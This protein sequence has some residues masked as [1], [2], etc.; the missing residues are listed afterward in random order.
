M[1]QTSQI[2]PL[3]SLRSASKYLQS[4]PWPVIKSL[5]RRT[6]RRPMHCA[7]IAG[8]ILVYQAAAPSEIIGPRTFGKVTG[9]GTNSLA[10]LFHMVVA[11]ASRFVHVAGSFKHTLWNG[12]RKWPTKCQT[13]V[14]VGFMGSQNARLSSCHGFLN[15]GNS[16]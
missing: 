2:L 15:K 6:P 4:W 11:E 16:S 5:G 3:S 9:H 13:L 10:Q 1:I 7:E 14:T 8:S 12:S